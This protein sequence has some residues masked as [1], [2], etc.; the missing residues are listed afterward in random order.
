MN[1]SALV[2]I[3]LLAGALLVVFGF[4]YRMAAESHA[5]GELAY[6]GILILRWALLGQLIIFAVLTI[7]A[8]LT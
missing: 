6:D 1:T 5:K 2:A 3:A 7:T 8:F 4:L